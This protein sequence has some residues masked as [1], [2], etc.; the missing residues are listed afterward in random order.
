MI[1]KC[2]VEDC[3]Y[4]YKNTCTKGEIEIMKISAYDD[5]SAECLDYENE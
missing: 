1:I 4:N 3:K 5:N 2:H